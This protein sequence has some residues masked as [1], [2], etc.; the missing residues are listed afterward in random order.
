MEKQIKLVFKILDD[1]LSYMGLI[2]EFLD[3]KFGKIIGRGGFGVVYYGKYKDL[4]VVVK[5]LYVMWVFKCWQKE[6]IDE[7]NILSKLDNLFI[8]KF[9]GVCIIILDFCIVLEYMQ[10]SLYEVLYVDCVDLV[11]FIDGDCLMMIIQILIGLEYL[12]EKKVV[13]CDIKLRNVLIDYDGEK[14]IV[15]KLIDFGLSMMKNEIEILLLFNSEF[16]CYIGIFCYFFLEVFCGELMNLDQ[17]KMSD[18]YFYGL[19]VFEI[20]CEEEFFFNLSI[21]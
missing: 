20:V 18:M 16:V 9:I 5:K 6:F 1:L 11:D 8:V 15:V 2:L 12:Y 19:V 7:V 17:M 21:V 13:Y 14:F 4:V 3:I 10:M